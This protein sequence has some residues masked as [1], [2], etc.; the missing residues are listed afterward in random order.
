MNGLN[1][2]FA[3]FIDFSCDRLSFIQSYLK[4][5]GVSSTILPVDGKKHIYVTFP[6]LQYNAQ[7][8]IKTVIAHYDRVPNTQGANDNSAAVFALMEW[9]QKLY[10]RTD[11]HNVRM[12]FTDGE[13]LGENG[14]QEQGSFSLAS[15]FKKLGLTND[16]IFVFDAIGRGS[17]PI[18]GKI[19][20]PINISPVFRKRFSELE[21]KAQKIIRASGTNQFLTLPLPYSDNAGFLSCGIPAIAITMLPEEEANKYHATLLKH[22]ALETFITSGKFSK[23]TNEDEKAAIEKLKTLLPETWKLF[24]TKNDNQESL[25]KESFTTLE[26]ILDVLA[27]EKSSL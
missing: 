25:T 10:R 9:A 17:V 19:N 27:S 6:R 8:R 11:F 20:L 2:D 13:E 4:E 18:I 26:R 16:D 3:K 1:D 21:A 22:K 23:G 5:N 15:L 7:Y 12:L 24:H 14:I